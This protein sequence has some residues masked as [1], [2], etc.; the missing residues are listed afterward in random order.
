[1]HRARFAGEVREDRLDHRRIFDARDDAHRAAAAR[2]GL[3]VDAEHAL[4]TLRPAHRGAALARRAHIGPRSGCPALAPTGSDIERGIALGYPLSPLM[5]ALYLKPLGELVKRA[6]CFYV[7]YIGDWVVLASAR[8][9]LQAAIR[10]ANQVMVALRVRQHPDKTSIGRI[11]RGFDFL[12]YH[13][14]ATGMAVARQTYER[15]AARMT[16]LF[17][18]KVRRLAASG[19]MCDDGSVG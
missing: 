2:A 1:V 3:D 8:W 17:M 14:S 9:K 10:A 19:R 18:S 7:R 5:G 12:G 13:F 11:Q 15:C 4:Q 16:R 6:D